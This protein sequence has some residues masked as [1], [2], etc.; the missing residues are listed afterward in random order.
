MGRCKIGDGFTFSIERSITG[1]VWLD[2]GEWKALRQ[3]NFY[4]E[5][6]RVFTAPWQRRVRLAQAQATYKETL[7]SAF[8]SDLLN[9]LTFLRAELLDHPQFSLAIAY[10]A[11]KENSL[12]PKGGE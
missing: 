10:L 4:D 6:H 1:G 12:G 11:E 7:E 5:I 3:R 8:G 2:G 9:R